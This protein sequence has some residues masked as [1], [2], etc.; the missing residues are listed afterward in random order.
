M[1]AIAYGAGCDSGLCAMTQRFKRV[2]DE[3]NTLLDRFF[4]N[5]QMFQL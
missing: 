2:G 5:E 3:K 1:P 4:V